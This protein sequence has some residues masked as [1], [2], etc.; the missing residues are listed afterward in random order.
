M[1]E[2]RQ[3]LGLKLPSNR[4]SKK[5]SKK[6]P[7]IAQLLKELATINERHSHLGRSKT[8][9]YESAE[10]KT[11][12]DDLLQKL[13]SVLWPDTDERARVPTWLLEP[14]QKLNEHPQKRLHY[15]DHADRAV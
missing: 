3:R 1:T 5:K 2:I 13:G 7:Q 14:S 4:A 12:A 15:S 9:I 11:D 6:S 10:L 8:A